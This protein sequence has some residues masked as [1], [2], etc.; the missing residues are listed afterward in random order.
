M[1]D[2]KK[3]VEK[4]WNKDERFII[5]LYVRG[6]WDSMLKGLSSFRA[7]YIQFANTAVLNLYSQVSRFIK[8]LDLSF[9]EIN[10]IFKCINN[11]ILK[12]TFL[13]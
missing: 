8:L 6:G 11:S 9:I 13:Y 4:H 10:L 3:L 1:T 5:G 2:D 12:K 7:E